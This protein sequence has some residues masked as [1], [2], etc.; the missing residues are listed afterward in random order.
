MKKT[1]ACYV[2]VSTKDQ[3]LDNQE[4]EL[5]KWLK[6]NEVDS[7]SVTWYRDQFSGTTLA[8]P[9]LERLRQD[10]EK[11]NIKTIVIWKLDRVSRNLRDGVNLIGDWCEKGVRI[12]SM[13]EQL[14]FSSTV[15]KIIAS[16]LSGLAQMETEYR[17]ERQT[18]GINAAKKKG[19]VY[20][21]RKPGTTKCKPEE[22]RKMR[23]NGYKISHI[24]GILG[25]TPMTVHRYLKKAKSSKTK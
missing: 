15:G 19:N 3:N 21:G 14:D 20:M 12:V 17:K 11:G 16:L 5:K 24:A 6:A 7:S 18:V 13:T 22:A 9:E 2:R 10:I 1:T 23:Q 8:R 25:V 4:K